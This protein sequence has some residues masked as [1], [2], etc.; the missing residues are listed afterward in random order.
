MERLEDG[1]IAL[2]Q[3]DLDNI[4]EFIWNSL[5]REWDHYTNNVICSDS[6][7]N[8]MRRMNPEMYDFMTTINS[9]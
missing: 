6:L 4:R 1:R 5:Y 8:G 7:E 2:I 9:I 3:E